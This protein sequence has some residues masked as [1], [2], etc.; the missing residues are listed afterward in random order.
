[1]S[2]TY[3]HILI[4][5]IV[6]LIVTVSLLMLDRCNIIYLSNNIFNYN[7]HY[8]IVVSLIAN[9]SQLL[10]LFLIKLRFECSDKDNWES[11]CLS[12]FTP[13][14]YCLASYILLTITTFLKQEPHILIVL[15]NVLWAMSIISVGIFLI[16]L[17]GSA[18]R[19]INE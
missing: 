2:K 1:M 12:G 3:K 17:G 16:K 13:G 5:A 9:T 18:S 6:T 11:L 19:L 8:R 4:N 7:L 14:L 15:I 10:T